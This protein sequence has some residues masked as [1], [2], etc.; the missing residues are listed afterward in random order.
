[1][2]YRLSLI[3]KLV[4]LTAGVLLVT[5]FGT[6]QLLERS[7][8]A[9]LQ[10]LMLKQARSLA[11]QILH[12]RA[13]VSQHQGVYVLKTPE[14]VTNP[15]LY[16]VG[17]G[18]VRPEIIDRDGLVYTLK[19]HSLVTEELSK[20][21]S[22]AGLVDYHLTS[23]NPLNPNNAP[24]AFEQAGLAAFAQGAKE[25]SEVHRI[26]EVTFFRYMVPLRVDAKCLECHGVQ[27]YKIGDIRGG[28][29]LEVPMGHEVALFTAKR[30]A[31]VYVGCL[32]T[33]LV[34]AALAF[35]SYRMII[36][37]IRKLRAFAVKEMGSGATLAEELL[38]RH[39]EIGELS[40]TL[41]ESSGEIHAYREQ[42]E[43]L[44]VE[45]TRELEAAK[46]QLDLLS[47]TDPLTGLANRRHLELE[48][49]KLLSLSQ[50]HREYTAVLMLDL[51]HF[52]RCNDTYG[53]EVGDQVLMHVA[54]I[55]RS[56]TRPYDLLVRYG[57]E[58][59]LLLMPM[60]DPQESVTAA[61]RLREQLERYPLEVNGQPLVVTA[62]IGL[63][64]DRFT[65]LHL[66]ISLAD[67]ALY[68]AKTQ[69]RNRVC[70]AT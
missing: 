48:G 46:E 18:K 26:E 25:V 20:R 59:F 55:L 66:A 6:Y 44:V 42:L 2:S 54:G 21:A 19:N 30:R 28:L 31:V 9:D 49:E 37:P 67:T 70:V 29:S 34:L 3:L 47:R 22:K 10:Q 58:E 45:R 50:R 43:N 1:M 68:R 27:G 24:D 62:S 14:T 40:R 51:D 35:M 63:Y 32:I 52:K 17:P 33:L 64:V 7:Q 61:E 60:T 65:D 8:E 39:D 41:Q 11:Q 16:H 12:T 56:T 57:G 38:R 36:Q 4:L 69:G 13:W 5:F 53:H 23:L 15:L